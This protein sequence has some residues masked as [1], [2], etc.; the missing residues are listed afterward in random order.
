MIAL[1][2]DFGAQDIY[3]PQ[4]KA[5]LLQHQ[6]SAVILDLLHTVAQFRVESA[7]HLLAALQQPFPADTVFLAV[8]VAGCSLQIPGS[9]WSAGSA[10][11]K[12]SVRS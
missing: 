2:T 11:N 9:P 4:M 6:P 8:V 12:V 10:R 7:A 5:V 1:F 3:V